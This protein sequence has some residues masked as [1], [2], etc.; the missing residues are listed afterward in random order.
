MLKKNWFEFSLYALIA[1]KNGCPS[2]IF[3]VNIINVLF[4]IN[5]ESSYTILKANKLKPC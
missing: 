1:Y 2:A 3:S 5:K 4:W